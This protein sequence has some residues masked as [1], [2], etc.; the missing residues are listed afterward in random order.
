MSNV[1]VLGAKS[2]EKN[3]QIKIICLYQGDGKQEIMGR[4]NLASD[5]VQ[6][7]LR[8]HVQMRHDRTASLV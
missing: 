7:I 6:K 4:R 1:Q 3:I 8:K 5:N 2:D